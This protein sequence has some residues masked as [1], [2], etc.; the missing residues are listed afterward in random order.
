MTKK[1]TITEADEW[2][3]LDEKLVE[4][5]VPSASFALVSNRSNS[6][7]QFFPNDTEPTSDDLG[8]ILNPSQGFSR[9]EL[10]DPAEKVWFKAIGSSAIIVATV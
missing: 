1:V 10:P 2:I 8:H 7:V 9:E 6:Q 4:M 5:G 3:D